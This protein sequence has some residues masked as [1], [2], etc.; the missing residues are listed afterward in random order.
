MKNLYWIGIKESDIEGCNEMYKAS[1]TILG[2]GKNGNISYSS[3]INKRINHNSQENEEEVNKW[4]NNTALKILENNPKAKFMFYNQ[5]KIFEYD[6]IVI[7]NTICYN[8]KELIN[9]INHKFLMREWLKNYVPVLKYKYIS[10]KRLLS[11]INNKN[12]ELVIQGENSNG[13]SNTF[14]VNKENV[15]EIENNLNEN[16]IY[17]L[18]EYHKDNIPIN[19]HCIISKNEITL[20]PPSLQ[21]IREYK[22]LSYRGADFIE[23]RKIEENIKTNIK[24]Y[25]YKICTQLQEIGYRGILGIDYII[26]NQE[27]Y[28]MEINPRFQSSTNLLNI[29]L[30]ENKQETV[31]ELCI[32]AFHNESIASKEIEVNYS[33]YIFEEDDTIHKL[34]TP[35]II[36]QKDGF[37]EKQMIKK[38]AYKYS[39]IYNQNICEIKDNKYVILDNK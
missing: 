29:A 5:E 32:K 20:F 24:K 21:I 2:S 10:K 11:E 14:L 38:G 23:Y 33:K 1:I 12:Q 31:N 9:K 13:G 17:S 7:Q 39:H 28:F 36:E 6:N 37:D 18:S 25:S 8:S 16:D 27:I 22:R 30:K 4:L 15:H 19:I 26:Y 34:N 3:N 35:Y